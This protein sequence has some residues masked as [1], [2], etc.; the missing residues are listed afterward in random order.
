MKSNFKILI[1]YAV[2]IAVI[3]IA[4]ATL[5]GSQPGDTVIYSEIYEDFYE[6][7][8]KWFEIDS[9][10]I[11]TYE[12]KASVLA[13]GDAA[14]GITKSFKLR[15]LDLFMRSRRRFRGGFPLC[16]MLYLSFLA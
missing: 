9:S 13:N 7:N 16:R 8:V 14:Q 6:E 3:L 2:L 15:D 1:F 5:F 10:N 4:T 11:L 12:T